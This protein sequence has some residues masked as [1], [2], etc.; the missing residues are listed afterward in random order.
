MPS[1]PTYVSPFAAK[2]GTMNSMARFDQMQRMGG[3]TPMPAQT[4][5]PPPP[6]PAS[7]GG[8]MEG[9]MNAL[10]GYF[11]SP[12]PQSQATP[13]RPESANQL[14]QSMRDVN[15]RAAQIPTGYK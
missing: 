7:A 14:L 8:I 15:A 10:R 6:Q 9:L 2:G 3:G 1:D 13:P 11:Q 12:L 5:Q 4:P